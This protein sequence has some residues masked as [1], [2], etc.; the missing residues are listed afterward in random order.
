MSSCI[1][2]F[3]VSVKTSNVNIECAHVVGNTKIYDEEVG[4]YAFT[5]YNDHPLV[6]CA[7]HVGYEKYYYYTCTIFHAWNAAATGIQNSAHP[8][9]NRCA[10]ENHDFEIARKFSNRLFPPNRVEIFYIIVYND[11]FTG[12]GWIHRVETASP[13]KPKIMYKTIVLKLI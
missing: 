6:L 9:G 5:S 1:R 13:P 7:A 10:F 4:P 11:E 3:P 12:T 2:A 8:E